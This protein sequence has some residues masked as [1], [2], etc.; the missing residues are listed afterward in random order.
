MNSFF[1]QRKTTTNQAGFSLVETLVAISI[2]LT[3]VSSIMLLVNQSIES[4]GQLSDQLTA[5]YLA[6]DAIEYIRYHRDSYLLADNDH[7]FDGWVSDLGCGG[8][9]EI[10][11]RIGQEYVNTCTNCSFLHYNTDPSSKRY[12]YTNSPGANWEETKFKRKI[13][14]KYKDLGTGSSSTDEA[15]IT[16]TVGW[17][18]PNGRDSDL[19]LKD[20][21]TAWGE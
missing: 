10:D 5:S 18:G 9:C 8:S 1:A 6:S 14:M 15:I 13:S 11:T 4:S 21:I 7:E 17:Q 3:V 20:V 16:V 2:L 12:G 19:V